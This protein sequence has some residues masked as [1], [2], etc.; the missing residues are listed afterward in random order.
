MPNLSALKLVAVILLAGVSVAPAA[1]P[2]IKK[3]LA[4]SVWEQPITIKARNE[5]I[6][7]ILRSFATQ[8]G[9]QLVLDE[10][11]Q[12]RLSIE[13]KDSKLGEV[14][15]NLCTAFQCEWHISKG[16]ELSLVVRQHLKE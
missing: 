12:G 7:K 6:A 1:G 13:A 4:Q 8:V 16:K 10:N 15:D 3:D 2:A 14:M 5:D 11:I 9:A